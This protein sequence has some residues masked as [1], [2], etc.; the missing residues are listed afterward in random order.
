MVY[1]AI[2]Y[3]CSCAV[4]MIE[5]YAY[6]RYLV[7]D[8]LHLLLLYIVIMHFAQ[9]IVFLTIYRMLCCI[10]SSYYIML[11]EILLLLLY[12]LSYIIIT[13]QYYIYIK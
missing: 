10:I 5:L 1:R 2:G 11:H 7:L 3:A 6:C 4:C 12:K 9:S 8:S 13:F